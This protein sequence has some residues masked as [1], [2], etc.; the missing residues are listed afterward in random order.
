MFLFTVLSSVCLA[1]V[2]VIF[3]TKLANGSFETVFGYKFFSLTGFPMFHSSPKSV[4]LG[5][6]FLQFF[7]PIT[8]F[9]LLYN[10]EKTQSPLIIL[11]CLYLFGTQLEI[12]K[13]LIALFNLAYTFSELFL[14]LGNLAFLGKL[15]ALFSF[16]LFAA[17]SKQFQKLNIETDIII[18]ITLCS[19]V[20]VCLPFNTGFPTDTFAIK[21]GYSKIIAGLFAVT[22]FVTVLMF[23]FTYRET[24]NKSILKL[25]ASYCIII[26]GQALLSE[27]SVLF[28]TLAG[29]ALLSYGTSLLMKTLHR[30]Y[31]WD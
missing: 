11:Y 8:S 18:L 6:L 13:L 26:T 10:F 28:F 4:V 9:L 7:I 27:T 29:A 3:I 1:G 22:I 25:L 20:T 30:M 15:I 16:F 5:L 14:L 19:A 31:L 23:V 24:E 2:T 17:E 12:S 21:P